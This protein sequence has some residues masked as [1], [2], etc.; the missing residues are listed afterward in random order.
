ML[1]VRTKGL[2]T[3]RCKS[4]FAICTDGRKMSFTSC[5]WQQQHETRQSWS[6]R[7][8]R[9]TWLSGHFQR[10]ETLVSCKLDFL[11]QPAKVNLRK[12]NACSFLRTR[13]N[14]VVHMPILPV[15]P[16]DTTRKFERFFSSILILRKKRWLYFP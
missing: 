16:N 10:R 3:Q 1:F 9:D 5:L 11:M 12:F 14:R 7:S 4:N 8:L 13:K 6:L 2:Q 15:M